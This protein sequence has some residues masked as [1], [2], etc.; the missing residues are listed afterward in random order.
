MPPPAGRRD[1]TVCDSRRHFG[2]LSP[3]A[4]APVRIEFWGDDIDSISRFELDSQRRTDAIDGVLIT[5]ACEC[6]F[7]SPADLAARIRE[8]VKHL[9]DKTP[10]NIWR[11]TSNA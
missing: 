1:C 6:L 4:P 9:K 10:K 2:R 5:P 7:D 8:F 11:T 3:D